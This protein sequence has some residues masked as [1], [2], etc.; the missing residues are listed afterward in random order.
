[1][2][3][4]FLDALLYPNCEINHIDGNKQNN[5]LANLEV[6]SRESNNKKYLD[7]NELGLNQNEI[8]DITTYC[9]EHNLTLKEYILYKI[10]S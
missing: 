7:L 1:M 8:N 5:K 4:T 6:V 3:A 9:M 2:A 10:R